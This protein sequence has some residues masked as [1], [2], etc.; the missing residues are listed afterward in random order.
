MDRKV[1]QVRLN[2]LGVAWHSNPTVKE[3]MSL[4]HCS[5]LIAPAEG[6]KVPLCTQETAIV[7]EMFI[8]PIALE[9]RAARNLKLP[10]LDEIQDEFLALWY[11]FFEAREKKKSSGRMPQLPK[12]FE[13]PAYIQALCRT[14]AKELKRLMSMVRKQFLSERISREPR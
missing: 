1:S 9:M 14:D 12:N 7:N 5:G 8:I 10:P 6:G 11:K 4:E 3:R 13:I 2:G